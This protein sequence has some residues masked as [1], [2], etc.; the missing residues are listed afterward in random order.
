MS[1]V[2]VEGRSSRAAAGRRL[3]WGASS[4][5]GAGKELA[6]RLGECATERPAIRGKRAAAE[7]GRHASTERTPAPSPAA[8]SKT[9]TPSRA[10][11][12]ASDGCSR[13]SQPMRAAGQPARGQA[14]E[15]L[16]GTRTRRT[17]REDASPVRKR[18]APDT[19]TAPSA[20]AS[21]PRPDFMKQLRD[22]LRKVWGYQ[23]DLSGWSCNA[24]LAK[25]SNRTSGMRW[26]RS[27]KHPDHPPC[28]SFQAVAECLG[29]KRG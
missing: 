28:R 9:A 29:L 4:S 25:D 18:E 7:G 27:F 15:S 10:G 5:S 14:A 26:Y 8:P 23:G 20:A 1:P 19:A 3:T 24:V 21:P 22:E 16:Q 11:G 6:A 17:P 13:G 2:L 12:A